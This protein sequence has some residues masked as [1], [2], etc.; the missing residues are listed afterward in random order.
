MSNGIQTTVH[1]S[2]PCGMNYT[3]TQERTPDPASGS[4]KCQYCQKSVHEWKGDFRYVGW[5]ATVLK[6]VRPGTRI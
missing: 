2:C 3:A 6:P 1:F 4:F 5:K